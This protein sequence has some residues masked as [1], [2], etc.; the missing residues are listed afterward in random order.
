MILHE[1]ELET[2]ASATNW[3]FLRP[4]ISK[5]FWGWY[6]LHADR[7]LTTI[8]WLFISKTIYARDLESVFILLFGP[9]I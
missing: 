8:K 5:A 1:L 7:K 3:E 9:R 4:L 6:S 2:E